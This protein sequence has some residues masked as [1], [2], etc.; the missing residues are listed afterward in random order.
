MHIK[1]KNIINQMLLDAPY[2][3]GDVVTFRARVPNKATPV[4][5]TS[6]I[7]RLSLSL[8]G[9]IYYIDNNT[10]DK[11]SIVDKLNT[12]SRRTLKDS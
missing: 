1:D 12:T 11:D 5:R 6:K 8:N 9:V 10:Y 3:K 4:L 2:Q 7:Q